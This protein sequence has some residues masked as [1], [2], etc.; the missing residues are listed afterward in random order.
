[1][2]RVS[3]CLQR[4]AE[5]RDARG[6]RA[7]ASGGSSHGLR[8]G[9][10]GHAY[11]SPVEYVP[12]LWVL[13]VSSTELGRMGVPKSSARATR[14]RA[15]GRDV[16]A[17]YKSHP[18]SL[19]VT[20]SRRS[21]MAEP[22][23][24]NEHLRAWHVSDARHVPLRHVVCHCATLH[25]R[26]LQDDLLG[27]LIIDP[28]ALCATGGMQVAP[29]PGADVGGVS[30]VPVQMWQRRAQSRC[31]CGRGELSPGA[32]VAAASPVPVPMWPGASPV[33]MRQ[34]R[35]ARPLKAMLKLVQL[36]HRDVAQ[37]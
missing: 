2:Q 29:S 20:A 34:T 17:R 23:D 36:G 33:P 24:A 14:P 28:D 9:Q 30:L 13:K 8:L 19:P 11:P 4:S 12:L 27:E 37:P 16:T 32:D 21:G 18:C 35:T 1:V 5:D 22:H 6:K 31:R 10:E 7:V 26:P 3:C 15:V 25:G